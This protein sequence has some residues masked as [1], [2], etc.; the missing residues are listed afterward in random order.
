MVKT[1]LTTKYTENTKE[2]QGFA[3]CLKL[4]RGRNLCV[5]LCVER[6]MLKTFQKLAFS[7][8][9]HLV[10]FVVEIAIGRDQRIDEVHESIAAMMR[11]FV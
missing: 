4:Q 11:R 1:S 6:K 2:S 3:G 9:V 5:G 10:S 8:F 7:L